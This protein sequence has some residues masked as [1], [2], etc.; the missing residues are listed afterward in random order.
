MVPDPSPNWVS[1]FLPKNYSAADG[2][3]RYWSLL[4]SEF[5][6]VPVPRV[7]KW[8]EFHDTEPRKGIPVET[9][10]PNLQ[11]ASGVGPQYSQAN[12]DPGF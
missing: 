2:I 4:L 8:T 7:E 12:P 1:I 5:R 10:S 11:M 9:L 6:S 3:T